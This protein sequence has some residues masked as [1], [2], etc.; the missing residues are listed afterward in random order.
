MNHLHA[1]PAPDMPGYPHQPPR[2]KVAL[3]PEGVCATCAHFHAA[4]SLCDVP[5]SLARDIF[6]RYGIHMAEAR[7]D[8]TRIVDCRAWAIA[9]ATWR[10]PI[11]GRFGH[12]NPQ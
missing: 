1:R 8:P 3:L 7:V 10:D 6:A 4:E 12:R 2:F 5:A 9:D 11:W